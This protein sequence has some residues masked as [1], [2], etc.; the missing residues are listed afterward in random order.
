MDT[1]TPLD[2]RAQHHAGAAETQ[3]LAAPR[4][5]P[6]RPPDPKYPRKRLGP[7]APRD[8]WWRRDAEIA[9][10][11]CLEAGELSLHAAALLRAVL[12]FSNDT[13]AHIWA[14]QKR[15]GEAMG[16][17]SERTARRWLR[18]AE[19]RGWVEVEH[20]CQR[21]EG[22]RWQALTNLTRVRLP[23]VVEAQRV[24]RKTKTGPTARA[25]QNRPQVP[26]DN[27]PIIVDTDASHRAAEAV[28]ATQTELPPAPDTPTARKLRERVQRLRGRGSG[29]P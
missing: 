14:S 9:I 13:G 28:A 27:R 19:R 8:R 7:C 21:V 17:L 25:P 20:R 16:G 2:V 22:G 1:V 6:R 12:A 15:I 26:Q 4:S 29:P 10:G 11:Q 3:G 5:W 18:E 24:E 23:D